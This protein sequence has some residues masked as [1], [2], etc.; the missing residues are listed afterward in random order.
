MK[1]TKKIL[2]VSCMLLILLGGMTLAYY[3]PKSKETISEELLNCLNEKNIG[4]FVGEGCSHCERQKSIIGEKFNNLNNVIDCSE[5]AQYCSIMNIS[6][7]PTWIVPI[8]SNK[9]YVG[10]NKYEGV[11]SIEQLKNISRC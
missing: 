7:V 6:L 10:E 2:L 8:Y 9:S 1:K 3:K 4:I 5:L 11:L